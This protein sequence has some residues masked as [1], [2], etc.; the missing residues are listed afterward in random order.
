MKA[1]L[2]F[3]EVNLRAKEK[4]IP[5]NN[6]DIVYLTSNESIQSGVV[7]YVSDKPFIEGGWQKNYPIKT[8]FKWCYKNEI[9]F[10]EIPN[11]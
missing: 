3:N 8:G 9:I 5:K 1:I 11:N 2:N 4:N 6:S 10:E 7:V